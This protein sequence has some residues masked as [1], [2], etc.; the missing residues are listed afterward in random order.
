MRKTSW[1]L[2]LTKHLTLFLHKLVNNLSL[3]LIY[4][5]KTVLFSISKNCNTISVIYIFIFFFKGVLLGLGL[6]RKTVDQLAEDLKLTGPQVIS[7]FNKFLT[8]AVQHLNMIAENYVSSN[9]LVRNQI[10]ENVEVASQG[11]KTLHEELEA[12]DKVIF[13]CLINKYLM[14]YL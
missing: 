3:L 14:K 12:A 7:F 6:Q 1:P 4:C 8:K 9:M 5:Y 2:L 13:F 10:N 11:G